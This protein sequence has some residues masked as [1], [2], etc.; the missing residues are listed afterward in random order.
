MK[1]L[2]KFVNSRLPISKIIEA[3]PDECLEII[4]KINR[5]LNR[6][7][8]PYCDHV[9]IIRFTGYEQFEEMF[10]VQAIRVIYNLYSIEETIQFNDNIL[11]S[12]NYSKG[13]KITPAMIEQARAVPLL[14]L[15][16]FEKIRSGNKRFTA[17]CPFHEEKTSSFH[18]FPTNTY[19]CF[20]CKASGDSIEFVRKCQGLSFPQAVEMLISF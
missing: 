4:P 16:H 19:H 17:L 9:K 20:G 5:S 11:R 3:F 2:N 15:H 13:G 7:L 10:L 6:K 14:T 8:K 1:I 18:V 12:L